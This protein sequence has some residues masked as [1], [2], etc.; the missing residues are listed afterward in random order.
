MRTV[1]LFLAACCA[2]HVCA[3]RTIVV[4]D[5]TGYVAPTLGNGHM[6]LVMSRHGSVPEALFTH[7]CVSR[8][9]SEHVATIIPAVSPISF[10]VNGVTLASGLNFVQT[11]SMDSA[12]V[13]TA[14]DFPDFRIS[15]TYRLLRQLPRV[16]MAD[17]SVRAT[18]KTAVCIVNTPKVPDVFTDVDSRQRIVWCEDGG[19]RT[20]RVIAAFNNGRDKLVSSVAYLYAQP[21]KLCGSDTISASLQAGQEASFT[22]LAALSSTLDCRDPYS[23][24][25]R[26]LIYALRQGAQQLQSDHRREWR[27]LWKGHVN[28]DGDSVLQTIADVALY[29]IYSSVREGSRRSIAPM[30]LTSDKY[31]GHIFWDADQ[32]I[33]PVLAV[34]NPRLAESLIDF[35]FD[36][37]EAARANAL[38]HGYRG[39]M[40]PWEADEAGEESTPTF[41]LTGPLEHNISA[42]VPLAAW[43]HFLVTADTLYLRREAYPIMSACAD[44]WVSR[45]NKN[46]DGTYSV[47]NVVGAD[48]YAIGVTDNAFTNA[49]ASKALKVAADAARLLGE[50][51]PQEWTFVAQNLR[52][53]R[54]PDSGIVL[55]HR[56]FSGQK[57]KQADVAL[58]A[59]PLGVLTAPDEIERTIAF[60]EPFLDREN[61]PAMSHSVMSVN[62][63]RNGKPEKAYELMMQGVRPYLRGP[64]HSMAETP[65]NGETYFMTGAGGLLQALIFGFGGYDITDR[66]VGK[67]SSPSLPRH[68]RSI[69]VSVPRL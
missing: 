23:D 31:S 18:R 16:L 13:T 22:I 8:A 67:I 27:E 33:Y 45:A 7:S 12:E 41:A 6:G 63:A 66:G 21:W 24:A 17:V 32:W 14:T 38:A 51:Y 44:F 28:I 29:N 34:L 2:L 36:T 5:T 54:H 40:Y 15:V 56:D 57:I 26:M 64:F 65:A 39:A 60:Y 10:T 68:I 3:N 9:T 52:L 50:R 19:R 58:L 37:L 55:E 4:T 1:A 61:G 42:V 62:Y 59:Y 35:R 46:P 48:E 53:L 20:H 43:S 69:T 30:G 49:A 47:N 25:E 11:L